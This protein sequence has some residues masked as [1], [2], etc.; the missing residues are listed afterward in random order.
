MVQGGNSKDVGSVVKPKN[1]ISPTTSE[2]R[3][4]DK[5]AN[6]VNNNHTHGGK[7][8]CAKHLDLDASKDLGKYS[9][10]HHPLTLAR[11]VEKGKAVAAHIAARTDLNRKVVYGT[12]NNNPELARY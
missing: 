2:M 5:G 4:F 9:L 8:S 12:F 7:S 1:F 11:S 10:N 3:P 6:G